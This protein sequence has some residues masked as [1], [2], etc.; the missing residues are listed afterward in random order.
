MRRVVNQLVI[1]Q[2]LQGAPSRLH[3]ALP[4]GARRALWDALMDCA[5]D[6]DAP[7]VQALAGVLATAFE[8][9]GTE[10]LPLAPGRGRHAPLLARWFPV[11]TSAWRWTG[12]HWRTPTAPRRAMTRS[13]IWSRC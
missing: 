13:K 12:A 3:G 5:T 6:S 8:R 7:E 9:F 2:H 10:R 1:G 4:S 11:P